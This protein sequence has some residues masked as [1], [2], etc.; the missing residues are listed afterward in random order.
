[1]DTITA[2]RYFSALGQETRLRT[3]RLLLEAGPDGMAAGAIADQLNIPH[4]TLSSHLS[5]LENTG[6]ICRTRY[7]RSIIYRARVEEL[8]ALLSY[9][10]EDCC[11][12]QPEQC[13]QLLDAALV[14]CAS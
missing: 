9:L 13:S 1:M 3:F 4:N 11:Q 5:L 10:I 12:G 6:L 8:R 14:S 2:I 7:G